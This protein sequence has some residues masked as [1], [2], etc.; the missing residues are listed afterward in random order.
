VPRI[1]L[2]FFVQRYIAEGVVT[3]GIK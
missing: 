2:Y 1:V 3:S